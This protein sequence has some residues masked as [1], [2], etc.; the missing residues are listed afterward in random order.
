MAIM[1]FEAIAK[2][3][4]HSRKYISDIDFNGTT[5]VMMSAKMSAE[6]YT[7][8]VLVGAEK[9]IAKMVLVTQQAANK[10]AVVKSK[11]I[12]LKDSNPNALR[13]PAAPNKTIR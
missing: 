4:T 1:N 5:G 3:E 10:K 13:I 9:V 12:G 11:D 2:T 7:D 6:I 8:S